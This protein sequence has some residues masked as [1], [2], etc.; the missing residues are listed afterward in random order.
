MRWKQWSIKAAAFLAIAGPLPGFNGVASGH[1]PTSGT[2]QLLK[3]PDGG[4]QPQAVID[5]GGTIHLLYF[6]GEPPRATFITSVGRPIRTRS[7]PRSGSTASPVVPWRSAP[8]AEDKR[9][10]GKAGRVHVAWNGSQ[11]AKPGNPRRGV[12][13]ALHAVHPGCE[14]FRAA[15]ERDATNHRAR[16]RRDDC[17]R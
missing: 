9:V 8:S 14:R 3:T 2:V 5:A 11:R 10:L 4:I 15:A 7:R 17:R 6:K 16:R 12:P 1:D 13:N